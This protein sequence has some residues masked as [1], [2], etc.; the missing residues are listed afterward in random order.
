MK[1]ANNREQRAKTRTTIRP[2]AVRIPDAY[3]IIGI[4]RS[5]LYKLIK[6]GDIATVKVGTIT[7]VRV[8]VLEAFVAGLN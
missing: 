7:L 8:E 1:R 3:R 4:G 2:L 5:K 6:A